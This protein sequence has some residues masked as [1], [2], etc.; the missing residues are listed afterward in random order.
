LI[1]CSP[2]KFN[3][4][5]TISTLKF[6]Q[7]AKF[8]K[9]PASVNKLRSVTELMAII[10]KLMREIEA[11]KKY[12]AVLEKDLSATKPIAN[13]EALRT[14]FLEDAA[15]EAAQHKASQD[16]EESSGEEDPDSDVSAS[17]DE[18]SP[19]KPLGKA[20]SILSMLPLPGSPVA[21]ASEAP[22]SPSKP[23]PLR[24]RSR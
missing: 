1:A 10:D 5:E 9:N 18:F 15:K 22:E 13:L 4:E 2:H 8:I 20:P 17:E 23:P 7:R 14:K 3:I 6:G 16:E 11:L 12:I 24:T 21:P 19:R